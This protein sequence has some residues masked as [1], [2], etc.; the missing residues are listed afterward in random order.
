MPR[1]V[2]CVIVLCN[3]SSL[4]KLDFRLVHVFCCNVQARS[5]AVCCDYYCY[6]YY[7]YYYYSCSGLTSLTAHC[8]D[9]CSP[10]QSVPGSIFAD[11]TVVVFQQTTVR[12]KPL[13]SGYLPHCIRNGPGLSRN[14]FLTGLFRE[15]GGSTHLEPP[16]DENLLQGG[17][18]KLYEHRTLG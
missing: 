4:S 18:L 7:Y 2:S 6:Y 9:C 15:L 1:L 16:V 17:I 12:A 8:S 14:K 3:M 10:F 13:Q 5:L 11:L